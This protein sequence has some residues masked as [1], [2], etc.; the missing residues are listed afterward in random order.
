MFC[1]CG[2]RALNCLRRGGC[3]KRVFFW[4]E[5]NRF[6]F[7]LIWWLFQLISWVRTISCPAWPICI[8][9]QLV[10]QVAIFRLHSWPSWWFWYRPCGSLRCVSFIIICRSTIRCVSKLAGGS[11]LFSFLLISKCGSNLRCGLRWGFDF[12]WLFRDCLWRDPCDVISFT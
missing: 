10:L 7:C 3:M 2:R 12:I 1:W 5:G 8:P 6:W 4:W 9:Y 11:Y